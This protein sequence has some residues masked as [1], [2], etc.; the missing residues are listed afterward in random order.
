MDKIYISP[1]GDFAMGEVNFPEAVPSHCVLERLSVIAN[2]IFGAFSC[3]LSQTIAR[4]IF[5]SRARLFN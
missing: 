4:D 1:F 5:D 3:L 2:L